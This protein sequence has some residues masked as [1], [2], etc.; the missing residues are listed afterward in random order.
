[1]WV[2]SDGEIVLEVHGVERNPG[3]FAVLVLTLFV[4]PV[5]MPPNVACDPM[6][7]D[8]SNCHSDTAG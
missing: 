7:T 6:R 4:G 1:L 3:L 5:G 8:N 2:P